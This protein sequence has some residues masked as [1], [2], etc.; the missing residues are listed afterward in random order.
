MDLSHML[1]IAISFLGIFLLLMVYTYI[2]KLEKTGCAC[3]ES[4]YRDYIK[5]FSIFAV[6]Y[7][8]ITM[9]FPPAAAV[10]MF[11]GV[12]SIVY[13]VAHILFVILSFVFLVLVIVYVRGLVK[14]KCECSEDIRREVMYL[15]AILEIVMLSLS[16]VFIL[17]ESIVVG[18]FAL[19][20]HT[21]DDMSK[22]SSEVESSMTNPIGALRKVPKNFKNV[23]SSLK[24]TLKGKSK[25]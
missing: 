22:S 5:N 10:K 7:L 3:S 9:I 4:K 2:D 24:K 11:G 17:L 15:Y 13:F 6:L 23:A 12:G 14:A 8:F 25:K 19:S 18:A 16:V 1:G 21:V 20:L